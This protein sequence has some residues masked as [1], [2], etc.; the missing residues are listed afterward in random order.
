[1]I[2]PGDGMAVVTQAMNAVD[3]SHDHHTVND[4]QQLHPHHRPRSPPHQSGPSFSQP[5]HSQHHLHPDPNVPPILFNNSGKH[6]SSHSNVNENSRDMTLQHI[7]SGHLRKSRLM[8]K[9]SNLSKYSSMTTSS[10]SNTQPATTATSSQPLRTSSQPVPRPASH[11]SNKPK[12]YPNR[13]KKQNYSTSSHVNPKMASSRY[14]QEPLS[15]SITSVLSTGTSQT[16]LSV[17]FLILY[18]R[19]VVQSIYQPEKLQKIMGN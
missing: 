18:F 4:P 6:V 1:M 7:T 5:S 16:L 12:A 11:P 17:S 15:L 19:C 3:S 14:Q 2:G 9:N 13:F 8:K 10:A